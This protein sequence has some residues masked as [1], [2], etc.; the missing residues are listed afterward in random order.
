MKQKKYH[1]KIFQKR[2]FFVTGI[3]GNILREQ[4]PVV[5]KQIPVVITR[6]LS[7]AI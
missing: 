2:A 6:G 7:S 4:I 1:D 5:L 3:T